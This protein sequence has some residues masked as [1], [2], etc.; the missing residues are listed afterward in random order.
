M[1][2]LNFLVLERGGD[3]PPK[4]RRVIFGRFQREPRKILFLGGAPFGKQRRFAISRRSSNQG[5][6]STFWISDAAYEAVGRQDR[7]G[8]AVESTW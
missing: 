1:D 7:C 5:D 4:K 3:I 8:G 6:A 2:M